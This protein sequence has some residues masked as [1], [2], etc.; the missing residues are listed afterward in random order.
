M[1]MIYQFVV[2]TECV[3]LLGGWGIQINTEALLD[4]IKWPGIGIV[5]EK[6]E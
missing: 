2:C 3:N 6:T 1:K 4:V 5:S